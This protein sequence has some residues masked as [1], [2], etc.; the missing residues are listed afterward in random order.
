M[1]WYECFS[2]YECCALLA[3]RL[4]EE[5][6][7]L[8]NI[9]LDALRRDIQEGLDVLDAGHASPLDMNAIKAKAWA[10]KDK[11]IDA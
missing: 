8:K 2:C 6:D 7:T 11:D 3:L 5:R 1:S 9:K 4:L 10:N